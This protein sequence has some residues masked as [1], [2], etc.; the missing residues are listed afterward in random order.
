M[1]K[2]PEIQL[3]DRQRITDRIKA[4][5]LSFL[6]LTLTLI[7][8]LGGQTIFAREDVHVH[9]VVYAFSTQEEAFTQGIF[10]AF[11]H[12][13]EAENEQDLIIESVFGPSGALAGRINLG[14]PADIAILSNQRHADLLKFGR[15][16]QM[17]TQPVVI[18]YSPIIIIT[19]PGNPKD[20]KDFADLAQPGLQL[21]HAD[22]ST[23]GA[24][25]WAILGEYG[26][27]LLESGRPASAEQQLK[28]V[29]RNVRL[30]AP[31]ARAVLL[32]F[33]VGAGDA[34]VTYEHDALLSLAQGNQLEIVV[35]KN[36][37]VA[38]PYAVIVD[39]NVTSD[40]RPAAE[41]L[42]Q[43]ILSDTGQQILNRYFHRTTNIEDVDFPQLMNTF[44]VDDLGGWSHIHQQLISTY[45]QEE[46]E[47]NLILEPI[48]V[49][50]TPREQ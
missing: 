21:L 24:G 50:E 5:T 17:E 16:V 37:I 13:W 22:P 25:E 47:P 7:L 38:Q 43:F 3:V 33:E 1:I 34:L 29:W 12:Q 27:A 35:P 9:L 28:N 30:M 26:S 20:I 19:R 6:V 48:S 42:I 8:F 44:T 49:I 10:P 15:R 46:I 36:T 40:E 11:E 32:L 23:S 4:A 14:E 18:S 45:W 31:S 41:A 2:T 39:K